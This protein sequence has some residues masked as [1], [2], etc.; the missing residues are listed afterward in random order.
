MY[1]R[2]KNYYSNSVTMRTKLALL[3]VFLLVCAALTAPVIPTSYGSSPA[4]GTVSEA[5]PKVTWSGPVKAPTGSADCTTAN[6]A[7]CD[8][9]NI[10]IQPPTAA[11]GPYLVE[12][13]LQPV[14]AG[15]WD[16]QVHGPNGKLL[17]G[18]GNSPGQTELVV[19][20]NPPAGTYT[21]AAAPFA[22]LTGADGNSYTAT[23]EIKKLTQNPAAQ[24][25][26]T[27]INYHNFA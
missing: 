7:A 18:S 20:I 15:D 17:D 3:A 26:D 19:L 2:F 5:N 8:N 6:N 4:A 21:V 13:K 24:G 9:Y 11:Y 25:T 22:P 14:L 16:M 23:A 1:R 10:T 12:I 27:N